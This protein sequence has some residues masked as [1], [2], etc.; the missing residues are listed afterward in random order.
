MS[1]A[2]ANGTDFSKNLKAFGQNPQSPSIFKAFALW[3]NT[4]P[5]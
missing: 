1:K 3:A 5:L 4:D 2:F